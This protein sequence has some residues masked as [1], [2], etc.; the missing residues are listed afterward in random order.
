MNR[1]RSPGLSASLFALF[2]DLIE[3]AC[4][5]YY[6]PDDLPILAAKLEAHAATLGTDSLY[7]YYYRLRYDDPDNHELDR[8]VEA[9]LVHETYFFRELAPLA[10]LV[11]GH[12]AE[13]IRT[14]GRARA[15]SAACSTGEEPFTL[16]MLLH[17][18]GL[19]D[20]VEL[21]ASDVSATAIAWANAG[22]HEGRV[23]R[24]GHPVDLARRYLV[25][26]SNGVS[27]VPPIRQAVR[28]ATVNLLDDPAVQA[29]GMFDVIIC[30]N[31]L[32]YFRDH[33]VVQVVERLSRAL[34]PG[35]VIAV[36]VAESLLRF[37]TR[38]ACEERDSSFFYRK[39]A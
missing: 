21:V 2:A 37:D 39:T 34:E 12:L 17:D 27:V 22:R 36:G 11:D 25:P 33:Q 18:R 6:K 8:L 30:R 26:S 9:I 13:T 23:L 5:V 10:Q 15:W 3:E 7:D 14:R 28:F 24:E 31:V 4:G 29:L 1:K 35:G 19:L 38:L 20:R 16:A 32:I